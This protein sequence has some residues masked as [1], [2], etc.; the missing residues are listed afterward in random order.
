MKRSI[1]V[2]KVHA[3]T[4]FTQLGPK[5]DFYCRI[6]ASVA[7]NYGQQPALMVRL[8]CN[9]SSVRVAR[10]IAETLGYGETKEEKSKM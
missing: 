1:G 3:T 7:L 4:E 6:C 10:V 8:F 5:N 2:T 9:L